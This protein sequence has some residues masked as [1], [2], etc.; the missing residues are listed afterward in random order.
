MSV[1]VVESVRARP[2]RLPTDG[3]QA[4][5]VPASGT[6]RGDRGSCGAVTCSPGTVIQ[7]RGLAYRPL[8]PL[9]DQPR[10]NS[11]HYGPTFSALRQ[12]LGEPLINGITGYSRSATNSALSI[13][14]DPSNLP[15]PTALYVRPPRIYFISRFK[16]SFDRI[17]PYITVVSYISYIHAS[18][19]CLFV[20]Y[21]D[22]IYS[23]ARCS[24]MEKS[25]ERV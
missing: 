3:R 11:S 23:M 9:V 4:L 17:F 5:E 20:R 24:R 8:D 21:F 10:E 25:F 22:E 6:D 19:I 1:L 12:C 14:A 13:Y 18:D 15:T 7:W 16:P 2:C